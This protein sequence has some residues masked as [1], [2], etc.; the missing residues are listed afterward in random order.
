MKNNNGISLCMI[1]KNE[2]LFIEQCLSSADNF[3]DEIIIADTGSSDKTISICKK[4]RSKIID[5]KWNNNFSDARNCS[6]SFAENDWILVLDADEK[7]VPECDLKPVLH[8]ADAGVWGFFFERLNLTAP[9]SEFRQW[10]DFATRLFRNN[11]TIKYSNPVHEKV[12]DSI[13]RNGKLIRQFPG[14]IE[15]FGFLNKTKFLEKSFKY[16]EMLENQI[17]IHPDNFKLYIMLAAENEKHCDFENEKKNLLRAAELAPDNPEP[18]FKTALLLAAHFQD[19]KSALQ[20]LGSAEK[21]NGPGSPD[22]IEP[23]E[24]YI[25]KAKCYFQLEDFTKSLMYFD[26]AFRYSINNTEIIKFGIQ[27]YDKLGKIEK[28]IYLASKLLDIENVEENYYSLASR[29]M[30]INNAAKAKKILDMI[31]SKEQK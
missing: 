25:N 27:L 20:Y 7:I 9:D 5:Y 1:V 26:K 14:K 28:T 4:F 17:K 29:Y 18:Y 23:F 2:E 15:H 8:K 11:K 22:K 12:D 24:I 21:F 19:Y 16:I 3:V 13:L 31:N 6:L 30:K 10:S